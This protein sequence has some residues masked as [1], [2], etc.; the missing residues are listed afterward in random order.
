MIL[1]DEEDI[2]RAICSDKFDSSTGRISTSLFKGPNTSVSRLT[3]LPLTGQWHRLA[4]TVQRLP[5]LRLERIGVIKVGDLRALGRTHTAN[6]NPHPVDITVVE[7]REPWNDAH[8]EVE[9]KL[10]DGLCKRIN[11]ALDIHAPPVGF[12]T[13]SVARV[14]P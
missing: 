10:S 7:K 2:A 12:D 3:V 5:G 9:P 13:R 4:S 11:Q 1:G 8:A 6:G 14:I